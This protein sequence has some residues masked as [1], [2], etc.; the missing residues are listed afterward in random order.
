MSFE[1]EA[2]RLGRIS[3]VSIE[4][5]EHMARMAET[6][7]AQVAAMGD[8]DERCSTCAFRKGTLPNQCADTICDALKCVVEREPFYC[9]DKG[10]KGRVCH[11][12]FAAAVVTKDMPPTPAPWPFSHDEAP[13]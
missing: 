6:A 1:Q 8:P 12:W 9:H 7:V 11:G 3:P 10:R 2:K 13:Q 4:A 5:G